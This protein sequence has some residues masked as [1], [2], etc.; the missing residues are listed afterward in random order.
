MDVKRQRPM[1]YE[2]PSWA[3]AG[4]DLVISM[5]ASGCGL[6][7]PLSILEI[8]SVP[9][10]NAE[11]KGQR[12]DS[13]RCLTCCVAARLSL[14]KSCN[15]ACSISSLSATAHSYFDSSSPSRR[16]AHLSNAIHAAAAVLSCL[17]PGRREHTPAIICVHT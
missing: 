14:A 9:K 17:V 10:L 13:P 16:D 2:L 1:C 11:L 7:H 15:L 3:V 4:C 6:A 5:C 8:C 12:C